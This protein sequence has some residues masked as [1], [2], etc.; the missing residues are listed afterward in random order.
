MHGCISPAA[1]SPA[2]LQSPDGAPAAGDV[3]TYAFMCGDLAVTAN[4]HGADTATV[5]FGERTLQM[6]H[7]PSGSGARYTD[8]EGNEFWTK[9]DSE[10]VLTLKDEAARNCTGYPPG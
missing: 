3:R 1:S 9:G 6:N 8:A 7:V 2:E 4:Y 10:G 5:A